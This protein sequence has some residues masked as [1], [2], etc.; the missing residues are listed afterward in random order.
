MTKL[1]THET[2]ELTLEQAREIKAVLLDYSRGQRGI[3]VRPEVADYKTVCT[4]IDDLDSWIPT[5][6]TLTSV[7]IARAN[8]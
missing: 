3:V 4:V 2:F 5:Q 8:E 7:L 1:S 6:P